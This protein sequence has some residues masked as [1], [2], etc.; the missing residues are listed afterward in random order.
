MCGQSNTSW[1]ATNGSTGVV[2]VIVV[3]ALIVVIVVVRLTSSLNLSSP[4]GTCAMC[5]LLSPGKLPS[6][7]LFLSPF[8]LLVFVVCQPRTI[9]VG[10]VPESDCLGLV[11]VV[12]QSKDR[13][14]S[15][16]LEKVL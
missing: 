2:L 9:P 16:N 8:G 12:T 6:F 13:V 10:I 1:T 14:L 5:A 7:G 11:M 15:F 3:V 4:S